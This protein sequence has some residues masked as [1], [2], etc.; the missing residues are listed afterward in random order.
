M[1]TIVG[2]FGPV[3]S[4]RDPISWVPLIEIALGEY[5]DT[6]NTFHNILK[7][8]VVVLIDTGAQRCAIDQD[9]ATTFGLKEGAGATSVSLGKS[10]KSRSYLGSLCFSSIPLSYSGDFASFPFQ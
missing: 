1:P 10:A 4:Y 3:G 8:N 5:V 9:L 6:P 2:R 7:N